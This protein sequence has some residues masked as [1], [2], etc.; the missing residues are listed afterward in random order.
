MRGTRVF[1]C[2]R[3]WTVSVHQLGGVRLL[4]DGRRVHRHPH[5]LASLD[6]HHDAL[7]AVL[8]VV[9]HRSDLLG[10]DAT[11]VNG[12]IDATCNPVSID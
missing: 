6:L 5:L 12:A 11:Q 7:E 2:E 3:G 1:G 8:R 9:R 4:H 10:L